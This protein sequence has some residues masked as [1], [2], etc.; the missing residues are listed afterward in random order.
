[1]A[2]SHSI[3]PFSLGFIAVASS[4]TSSG[5]LCENEPSQVE[6]DPLTDPLGELQV[7][8]YLGFSLLETSVE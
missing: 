4:P 2:R 3:L 7:I 5:P 8:P 6:E 1:M